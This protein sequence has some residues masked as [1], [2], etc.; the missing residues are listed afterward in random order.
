MKKNKH[1]ILTG[2]AGF[3]GSAIT[4][5]LLSEGYQVTV[6]D[7]L[8]TGKKENIPSGADFIE[9]ELGEESSYDRLKKISG[10]AVFHLA[11]QSS[12]EASFANPLY[13]LKS[14]VLSTFF[15]LEWS[16]RNNI[17]RFMY[18]SS[19]SVYGDPLSL[20]IHE[21]HSLHPKTFYAAAKASG[22]YA[23]L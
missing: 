2:G 6:L 1:I 20:P 12:G 9:V 5:R 21:K 11:G 15:L 7:N 16:R 17:P 23:G 10:E 18:S 19:M 13:D 22:Q 8:S 4:R 14:H 3:I